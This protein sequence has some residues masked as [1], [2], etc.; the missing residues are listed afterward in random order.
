MGAPSQPA[1]APMGERWP[2]GSQ[3]HTVRLW[4]PATGQQRRNYQGTRMLYWGGLHPRRSSPGQHELDRTMKVVGPGALVE[5]ATSRVFR[6]RARVVV[7]S[8]M[9][10]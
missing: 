6:T 8:A 5:L 7:F 1:F 10:G 3:D 2:L 9:A 4:D